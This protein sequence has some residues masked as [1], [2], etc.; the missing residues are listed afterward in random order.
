VALGYTGWGE[1]QLDAELTQHGW[2]SVAG[3]AA[4]IF[5]APVESRWPRAYASA[6][7]DLAKLSS[8]SGRA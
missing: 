8:V 1:G 7:I 3:D 6:G 4:L 2:L 5:D